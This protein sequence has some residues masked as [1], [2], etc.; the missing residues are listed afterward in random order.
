MTLGS[1]SVEGGLHADQCLPLPFPLRTPP[2]CRA[3]KFRVAPALPPAQSYRPCPV[4]EAL[5]NPGPSATGRVSPSGYG[6]LG[7]V[8]SGPEI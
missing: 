5:G 4:G 2:V 6:V 7:E 3:C 8:A 1:L